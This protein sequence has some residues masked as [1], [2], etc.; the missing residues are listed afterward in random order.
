MMKFFNWKCAY[1]GESVSSSE[2]R[3]I[4]HIIPIAKDGVNEIWNVVPMIR[5]LNSKKSNKNMELWYKQQDYFSEERLAKIR[6]WQEYAYEKYSE[7]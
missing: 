2:V 3:T 6:E 5:S 4:D 7:K 1:S